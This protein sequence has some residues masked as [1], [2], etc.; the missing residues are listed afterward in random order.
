MQRN[1][2]RGAVAVRQYAAQDV[3]PWPVAA[4]WPAD[5][6]PVRR[7]VPWLAAPPDGPWPV[8]LLAVLPALRLDRPC[9]VPGRVLA[10]T[11]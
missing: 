7:D 3:A 1:V 8:V 11:Y 10:R 6:M 2:G 5:G 9:H 4:A